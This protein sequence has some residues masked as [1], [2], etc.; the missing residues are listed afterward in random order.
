MRG[1]IPRM[2]TI[3]DLPLPHPHIPW[4]RLHY[5]L[6]ERFQQ[7]PSPGAMAWAP[8]ITSTLSL[9]LPICHFTALNPTS[10]SVDT[11]EQDMLRTRS[12]PGNHLLLIPRHN[13]G[14][15][16]TLYHS[17]S[18]AQ[19]ATWLFL[20]S[21]PFFIPRSFSFAARPR[22]LTINHRSL[23]QSLFATAWS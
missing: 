11:L 9:Q 22:R 12:Y 19:P 20:T 16:H 4:V 21:R 7:P 8:I 1:E 15:P 14:P 6:Q 23:R 18:T 5:L 17:E 2:T 13:A 3:D 10:S